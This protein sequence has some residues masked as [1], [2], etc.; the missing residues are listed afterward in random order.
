TTP[1]RSP[2]PAPS[3]TYQRCMRR[4]DRVRGLSSRRR[5]SLRCKYAERRRIAY[6][7]CVKRG[8]SAKRCRAQRR[9]AARRH[10]R[11]VRRT[12]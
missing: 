8:T 9:A 12:R 5:A 1:G 7:R 6:R 10:A 11:L 3:T 4:A 2:Q